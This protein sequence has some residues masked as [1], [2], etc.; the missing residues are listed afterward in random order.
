MNIGI[1]IATRNRPN[2]LRI[3][4]DTVCTQRFTAHEVVIVSSGEKIDNVIK[5]Y[6]RKIKIIHLHIQGYGQIQQKKAA[7]KLISKEIDWVLFL[8]DDLTLEPETLNLLN[9][10]ICKR[11]AGNFVGI[12]LKLVQPHHPTK[13]V[14]GR[15]IFLK[16]FNLGGK[17]GT[18]T[19]GGHPVSYVDQNNE[20][21]TSW[22]IGASIWKRE[23]LEHYN[24]DHY[25]TK[26][27]AYEDVIFSYS[28]SK[29]GKLIFF[30]DAKLNFQNNEITKININIFR[31]ATFWRLYF[32]QKNKNEFS[33]GKFLW[34]HFGRSLYFVA[35]LQGSLKY[36]IQNFIEVLLI[37]SEL[38]YQIILKKDAIWSILKMEKLS[39]NHG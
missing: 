31:S 18:I 24:F 32:I 22:L 4:L 14:I 3:L 11:S 6:S 13:N 9:E 20:F 29:L 28:C 15:S 2:Q 37:G 19:R 16:V 23:L 30:P 33:T 36:K 5:E 25:V 38:L 8:D 34:A 10:F 21:E 27:S 39:D 1:A 26:Y 17:P 7:T 12:G 35:T